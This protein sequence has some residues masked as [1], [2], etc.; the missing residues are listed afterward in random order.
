MLRSRSR[1]HVTAS[2]S[3]RTSL[4][5]TANIRDAHVNIGSQAIATPNVRQDS[6][7]SA[8]SQ[9]GRTR[10]EITLERFTLMFSASLRTFSTLTGRTLH[11]KPIPQCSAR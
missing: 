8:S 10:R 3:H 2:C 9:T 4:H 7:F 11:K 1:T 6:D 5:L